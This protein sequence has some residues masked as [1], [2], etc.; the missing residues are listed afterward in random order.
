MTPDQR[1]DRLERVAKLFVAAG[2]R[3]RE[4][5]REQNYKINV[6][7]HDQNKEQWRVE[8][9]ELNEKI[10]ILTHSQMDTDEQIKALAASQSDLTKSQKLTDEALRAFINS[11]RKG[12]NGNSSG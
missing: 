4:Q 12:G 3:A 10:N 8:S 5:S 6:S 11:I 1:L 7:M 2:L 9:H